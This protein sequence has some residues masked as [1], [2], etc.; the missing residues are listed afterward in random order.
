[1]GVLFK[2]ALRNLTEHKAKTLIIGVIVA[3]CITVLVVG[4]S[5]MDTAAE[6]IRKTYID[7]FTGDVII[8][9]KA[10][11][12]LTLFGNQ[13]MSEMMADTP[14]IPEY[15]ELLEFVENH[16]AVNTVNPQISG[17]AT[18]SYGENGRGF[19]ML[20][21]IDTQAYR[22][23]F[24]DNIEIIAGEWF[25]PGDE[26]IF[27][28]EQAK[29]MLE[30]SAREA[31]NG[32]SGNVSPVEVK[33]GNER[34]PGGGDLSA[35][36]RK[37]LME[38]R[39]KA[40]GDRKPGEANLSA[41][42]RKKM[43]EELRESMGDGAVTENAASEI[44]IKPGDK[45]LLTNMSFNGGTN[46]REVEIKGIFRFKDASNMQLNLIS[47]LDQHTMRSLAGMTIASD[48]VTELN[49][50]ESLVFEDFSDEDFFGEEDMFGGDMVADVNV[51]S[52]DKDFDN[53]LGDTS[54]RDRLS[55][56]DSGAWHFILAKVNSPGEGETF[57]KDLTAFAETKN[58]D[59]EI[60]NW[61]GGAGMLAEMT[62]SVQAGFNIIV[63]IIAIVAIIIIMNTIVISVTER[64]AEIGTMRAMGAQKGFVRSMIMLETSMISIFF[65]TIGLIL[66]G[67]IIGILNMT[68]IQADD[69]FLQIIFGGPELRPVLSL[70]SIGMSLI[71]P[72]IVGVVSSLYPTGVALK[73]E[74]VRAI[75]TD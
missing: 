67:I 29:N 61:R 53:I 59:I 47:L 5:M 48:L 39:R 35:E 68:G 3:L 14:N 27:I 75:Q 20:F 36:E 19:M 8:N 64:I 24:P 62:F 49:D 28:S 33:P 32:N 44:E 38:E 72:L 50:Q 63:L 7:S 25:Q 40:M 69:M 26:G 4:N 21:G 58:I 54:E 9:A 65:G 18:V 37:K 73:I 16:P 17:R 56:T 60:Q 57:I 71:I 22:Q 1:M 70:A 51:V 42:E 6:G 12:D 66:G 10:K 2:I 30:R 55:Q 52:A 46:I 41:E 15:F 74:P 13:D 11:G 31:E 23:M 43:M 45:I 34:Q